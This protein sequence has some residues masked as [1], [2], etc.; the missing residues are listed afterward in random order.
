MNEITILFFAT[1]RDHIG[2][3]KITLNVPENSLV[4]D[5]KSILVENYTNASDALGATLVSINREYAFD[6]DMIPE[7]AEVAHVGTLTDRPLGSPHI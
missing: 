7:G 6:E 2:K 5:L 3:R 1:M 4:K